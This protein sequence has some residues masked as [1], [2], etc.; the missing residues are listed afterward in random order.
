MRIQDIMSMTSSHRELLTK[1]NAKSIVGKLQREDVENLHWVAYHDIEELIVKH[2]QEEQ[3][4]DRIGRAAFMQVL[5]SERKHNMMSFY[6]LKYCATI[7]AA[8]DLVNED[9]LKMFNTV[10]DEYMADYV[11]SLNK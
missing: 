11:R 2:D 8:Y 9:L 5:K 10:D 3:E 6:Q 7:L 4:S 1:I